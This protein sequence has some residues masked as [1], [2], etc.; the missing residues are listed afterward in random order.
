MSTRTARSPRTA[1]RL[2]IAA[3]LAAG[4]QALGQ[5][6]FVQQFD[7]GSWQPAPGFDGP[8]GGSG[9][10]S[11][12]DINLELTGSEIIRVFAD[13]PE[14]TDIGVISVSAPDGATPTVLVAS[15]AGPGI[16]E[17]APLGSIAARSIG[18]LIAP[19]TATVQVHAGSITGVGIEAGRIARLDLTGNLDA[20]VIHWGEQSQTQPGIAAIDIDGSVTANGSVVAVNGRIDTISIAGDVLGD[21]AAQNGGIVSLD[22]DGSVGDDTHAPTIYAWAGAE[23]FSIQVLDVQGSIGTPANPARILAGGPLARVEADAFHAHFDAMLNPA[24]RGFLGGLIVRS[25]DL[26]GSVLV[27]ELTSYSGWSEAPCV[28]SVAGDLDGTIIMNRYVRNENPFGPEIDIAGSMSADSLISVGGLTN[29]VPALPGA[30]I[31]VGAPQG[32]AGQIIVVDSDA[33]PFD[34]SDTV[35]LAGD[36]L[37]VTPDAKYPPQLF[38]ELGGGSVGIAPFNFHSFESFPQHNETIDIEPG[39][40][41][42]GAVVRLYGP[43]FGVAPAFVIEHRADPTLPWGDRSADFIIDA[44]STESQ[45]TREI[46]IEAIGN[47]SFDPGEWRMRPVDDTLR[48]AFTI[49]LPSIGFDS[50]YADDTYRFVVRSECDNTGGRTTLNDVRGAD[51]EEYITPVDPGTN[52]CP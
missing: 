10:P 13:N 45:A 15:N 9:L 39:S 1:R 49:G 47:A 43:A 21:I 52:P 46:R 33:D 12:S 37:A 51:I 48:C 28:L 32:L 8:G 23:N 35:R 22:I 7:G 34:M 38:S 4:G 2:L 29:Q 19:A 20:P 25:G 27:E 17:A 36:G 40:S 30:E 44:A 5:S 26:N 16:N 42:I 41:L 3:M 18:G 24:D 14:T 6:I 11:G 50:E 31:R